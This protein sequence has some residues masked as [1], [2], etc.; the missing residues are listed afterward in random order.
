MMFVVR[1]SDVVF[2]ILS[3]YKIRIKY[4]KLWIIYKTST[5]NYVEVFFFSFSLF[6]MK[7]EG[8]KSLVKLQHHQDRH[9]DYRHVN[10]NCVLC[11]YWYI[12]ASLCM[13]LS[14][15]LG[16]Y[17]MFYTWSLIYTQTKIWRP[18]YGH[19]LLTEWRTG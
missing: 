8:R 13:H 3:A 7:N 4:T 10:I 14:Y 6:E 15:S 11:G 17:F 16:R 12:N 19:G 18:F 9:Y 2:K 5:C 1:Y